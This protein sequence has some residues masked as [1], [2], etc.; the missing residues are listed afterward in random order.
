[1]NG[2]WKYIIFAFVIV[3]TTVLVL[4]W[5]G[6][7]SQQSR[8]DV[9]AYFPAWAGSFYQY[10]GWGLEYAEFSRKIT[11]VEDG[12]LQMEDLSGTNLAQVVEIKKE[13]IRIIR[14][15]EEFYEKKSLLKDKE[16]TMN[17]VLL[18]APLKKGATWEDDFFQREIVAVD[19]VVTVPLGT[20][21]AV[22][23]VKVVGEHSSFYEYY[24]KNMGLIKRETIFTN[25]TRQNPVVSSLKEVT[26]IPQLP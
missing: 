21:H 15:Q 8:E 17:L 18:E 1:M 9:R 23:V 10:E 5:A 20:F 13:R 16:P 6:P 2:S 22:V 19:E 11:F 4:F 26:I 24:A 3:L 25:E 12:F 14:R 7:F